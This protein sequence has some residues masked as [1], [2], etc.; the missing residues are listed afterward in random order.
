ME[1]TVEFLVAKLLWPIERSEIGRHEI[2][3]ITEQI[4]EVTGAEIIDHRQ[5]CLRK[6]ILQRQG[7]IRADKAGSAGDEEVEVFRVHSREFCES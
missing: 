7:E 1:N 6:F 2:T 5:P 3:S 4:L